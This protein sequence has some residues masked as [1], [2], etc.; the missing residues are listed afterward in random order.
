MMRNF[1]PVCNK[2]VL[3]LILFIPLTLSNNLFGQPV[4]EQVCTLTPYSPN[5]H[6][7]W[8]NILPGDPSQNYVFDSLGG[9]LTIYS[10]STATVTGRIFNVQDSS[11]QWDMILTLENH[12]DYSAWTAQGRTTKNGGGASL[13]DQQNWTFFELDSTQSFFTGVPGTHYDGDTLNVYHFPINYHMGFQLG[14]GA[15][16]KN[17]NYGMSGWFGYTGSYSGK[18]DLNVN[19]SCDTMPPPPN[20]SVEIDTFYA[21][22]KSDSSFEMV[23]TFSGIGNNFQI[24]DDQGTAV[25]GNLSPGTYVFGDYFNSTDVVLIVSDPGFAACADTTLPATADC[26]PVPVCD[27]VIDTFYTEC[28]NDT[29]FTVWVGF[30]GSGSDFVISD[31]KNSPTISGL[32]AGLYS[33]GTYHQD[34]TVK[35]YV[36]HAL[37]FTCV[38][39]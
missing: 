2:L 36:S 30:S 6:A 34:S 5:G 33:Y 18:G 17:G 21:Q 32:P 24:S 19:A 15:N 23:V 14:V 35:I 27:L 20:C 39:T 26:T 4:I 16:D 28:L 10:N 31:D 11:R 1:D 22:C 7:V 29:N 8:L 37:L 38:K 3:F 12:Q 13:A 9:T 25:M